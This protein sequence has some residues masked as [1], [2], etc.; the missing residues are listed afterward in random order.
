M[1]REVPLKVTQRDVTCLAENIY[2]EARG[3]SVKGQV[4]VAQV[5]INRM[6]HDK[7]FKT[8]I[9]GVVY[10]RAQFSW[11]L[12][13][14]KK[15]KDSPAWRYTLALAQSVLDGYTRIPNFNAL[16]YHTHAVNP[17]WNRNKQIVAKIGSH[18]FYAWLKPSLPILRLLGFCICAIIVA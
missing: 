9:C 18:V 17:R 3:E 8:S 1:L 16:Y 7:Q 14:R 13:K 15:I 6:L 4:A 12:D 11:T 10:E 5:T 2:H